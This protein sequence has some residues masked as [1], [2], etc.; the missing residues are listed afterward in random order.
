VS[1]FRNSQSTEF[2]AGNAHSLLAAITASSNDAIIGKDL[3]SFITY[4]NEAAERLFGF[5]ATEIIGR[6]IMQVIPP[7]RA[8][9]ET[10]IL[11]QIRSGKRLTHFETERLTRSGEV[12]PVSLTISP[13]RD[14]AGEVVGISTI[15]RGLGESQHLNRELQQREA[16]LR[17]ILNTVPDGLVVID[18]AGRVQHFSPAA[19]R[20]FGY[21]AGEIAGRN[22]NVLVPSPH[23][24][25]HDSYLER[26]LST[27][28][29]R[30][31]GI[32]RVVV[33]RRKDG[34]TFPME[35]QIGE[36]QVAGSHLFTGFVRD[37]TERQDR[38]RRL[39]ELQSELLHVARLSELGQMVSALAH[40]VNQP[41]T[42]MANYLRGIRRL[43]SEDTPPMLREAIEKVAEQSERARGIVQSLRGLVRKETRPKQ[44]ESLEVMIQET[45]ALVLI[46]TTRSVSLDLQIAPYATHAFVDRV[47][48]QQVLLNLMRNAVEAMGASP[49]RTLTV[50]T[51]RHAGR[52]EVRVADTG[53]GLPETVR[54]RLF[55]PFVTTKSEGLGVGLSICRTIVEAHGGELAAENDAGGGTVFRFTLP[56]PAGMDVCGQNSDVTPGLT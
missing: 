39:A 51:E 34:T 20:M 28:E 9:E 47:Q 17:S 52:V 40:E 36:L 37:L 12:I 15:A 4:W 29:R 38:D 50:A 1:D 55:Q 44:V 27:G 43:L 22:V 30:I 6:S 7:E 14:A 3:N 48:I 23:A 31:I 10:S 18:Q 35:L 46:G 33:G 42:A 32:G 41:L 16:L 11:Q 54:A 56:G 13:I 19:E 2:D 8:D 26:Y 49:V 25:A 24:A 5:T 45:S 21:S 53:P